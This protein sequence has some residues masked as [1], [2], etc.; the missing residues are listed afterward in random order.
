M[1]N[2]QLATS[3]EVLLSKIRVLNESV[4]EWRV[5]ERVLDEWIENFRANQSLSDREELS[6]VY[7]VSKLIFFG[8]REIRELLRSMYR[9]LFCYPIKRSIRQSLGGALDFT[10]IQDRFCKEL[11]KTRFFGVGN[12][13]ESGTHLL[14]F[15]RQENN[16][17]KDLFE[18]AHRI[19]QRTV[20][21]NSRRLRLPQ[22]EHYVFLDDFCASG[23][24]AVEYSREIVEEVRNY[25][26]NV[27]VSYF[28][29]FGMS[30]GIRHVQRAT[31]FSNVE[32]VCIFDESFR[33]FSPDSRVFRSLSTEIDK[34]W[35]E[36]VCRENGEHI[37]PG[38]AL[39][40]KNGQMLLGFHHNVPDNTLPVIWGNARAG[41]KWTPLV[42]RY[43]KIY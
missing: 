29:L 1:S 15:F 9:D 30:D 6:L 8:D 41:Q 5:T 25:N 4:W 3:R 2:A 21:D 7:L 13:S 14:Y 23:T 39:G 43:H 22:V 38:H 12:P 18:S 37:F 35:L 10:L 28:A 42:R 31:A 11:E 17:P 32:A 33:V 16:L 27:D 36:R 24:Q 40:Y 26:P 19:F 34:T 20:G